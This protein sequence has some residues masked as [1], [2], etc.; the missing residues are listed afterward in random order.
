MIMIQDGPMPT[1]V[2]KPLRITGDPYKVQV[3]HLSLVFPYV[4]MYVSV[5]VCRGWVVN[6]SK[7]KGMVVSMLRD[8]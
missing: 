5:C 3:Y 1:G 4:C 2:D 7:Y 8:C 6:A